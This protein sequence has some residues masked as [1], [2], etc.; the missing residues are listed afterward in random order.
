MGKP[1]GYGL[2]RAETGVR[3]AII[4]VTAAY[5][6]RS[7]LPAIACSDGGAPPVIGLE[8]CL[9]EISIAGLWKGGGTPSGG[10]SGERR[11]GHAQFAAIFAF[12]T[13]A[14]AF[15]CLLIVVISVFLGKPISD[16]QWVVLVGSAV[17]GT[18]L[19]VLGKELDK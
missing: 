6:C 12:L 17:A 19:L 2:N 18:V 4:A 9:D 8:G 3:P 16:T 11:L 1:G 10:A 13:L 7:R 15:V 5:R 14:V